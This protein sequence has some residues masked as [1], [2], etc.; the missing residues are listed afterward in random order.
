[1]RRSRIR[2][3]MESKGKHVGLMVIF[4]ILLPM[5]S[6]IIGYFGAKYFVLPNLFSKKIVNNGTVS[7]EKK[8]NTP[9]NIQSADK[10]TE[11]SDKNPLNEN[12]STFQLKGF[13]IYAI[14]VGSFATEDNAKALVKELN[15]KEMGGYILNQGGFK[16]LTMAVMDRGDADI[17]KPKILE[18]YENAFVVTSDVPDVNIEYESED[19]QFVG[20]MEEQNKE[21]LK[22]LKDITLQ[23]KNMAVNTMDEKEFKTI[24]EKHVVSIQSLI[25]QQKKVVPSANLKSLQN[26]FVELEQRLLEGLEIAQKDEEG[27]V[28]T[29][30]ENIIMT[31]LYGYSDM[32]M[33]IGK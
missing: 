10:E 20:L 3:R 31:T 25:E 29:K 13:D 28:Y 22:I 30:V 5:V 7:N 14:Q 32:M 33:N 16:V 26:R 24:I 9:T 15:D 19:A 1:M 4:V 2:T 21:L 11:T 18:E 23:I 6:I 27:K 12:I 17:M 8:I